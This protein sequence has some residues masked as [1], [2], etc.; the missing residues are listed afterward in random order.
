MKT[1][2]RLKADR[3]KQLRCKNLI[4]VLENPKTIENIGSVVRN[5][6]AL[7]VQKLYVVDG[8]RLLPAYW[9]TMRE[10]GSLNKISVSAI[11]WA[12]VKCYPDTDSCIKYLN[13]K[14]FVSMVTSPHLKGKKN[15]I[16]EEGDYTHKKLAIWFGNESQGVSQAAIDNSECCINIPMC[17]IIESLNLGTSTGIVLYEATKQRRKYLKRKAKELLLGDMIDKQIMKTIKGQ[18]RPGGLLHQ[19]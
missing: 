19:L 1:N 16:L 5:I 4:A 9:Q 8:Y 11:K 2:L 17:G 13:S 7:G 18:Q 10:T 6:D 3:A 12:F 15:V 14:G